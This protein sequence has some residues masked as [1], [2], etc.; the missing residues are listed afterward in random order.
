MTGAS[1]VAVDLGARSGRV[2]VVDCDGERL[3]LRMARRFETPRR[4][5]GET[6]YQCWDLD[7]IESEVLAGVKAAAAMAPVASVG[8]DGWGV[9]HVLVVA[10]GRPVAPA[11]SY[12]DDRTRSVV[13]EVLARMPVREIY[14]R[15]GIQFQPFNTLY[16]LA[17]TARHRPD[18]LARARHCLML[19]DYLHV[20]LGGSLANEYTNATTTQ[21]CRLDGEWD[22]E[23]LAAAGVPPELF[24]PPVPPGTALGETAPL[25]G[26]RLAVIAPATHDTASAVAAIPM[27]AGDAFL[28]SG[29]WS[30]M[31]VES[32]RPVAGEEARRLN[33][34]NE[35]GVERRYRVLKNIAGLWLLQRL[36]AELD[37]SEADLV[38]AAGV[39]APWRSLIDPSDPRF[40]DPPSMSAAIRGF[41]AETGQPAPDDPGALARA[42]LDSLA[43]S[44]RRTKRELERLLGRSIARVHIGGGGGQNLLLDQLAADACEVEVLVGPTEVSVLGNACVQLMRLGLLATLDEARALVRRSFAAHT[45]AP[46]AR[47]PDTAW[48]RFQGLAD[49]PPPEE[50]PPFRPARS[51][52]PS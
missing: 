20:R 33:V 49:R 42:A 4:R 26:R 1:C 7:G 50:R 15:T 2:V 52:R 19:P 38:A 13:D 36:G 25:E 5:D 51:W 11:V 30:L 45:F 37:R 44:Y 9:D 6:G 16:Q 39:A 22:G 8:V 41:C 46:R 28:S 27:S 32:E 47:V 35:G 3:S 24:A 21:L 18:W 10:A 17:A 14:R 12:R 48:S 29:T 23:L 40:L 34:T 43:L 31:G